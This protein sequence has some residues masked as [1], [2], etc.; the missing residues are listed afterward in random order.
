MKQIGFL[1]LIFVSVATTAQ[2]KQINKQAID[3]SMFK[4]DNLGCFYFVND[5]ELVK[6][7]KLLDTLCTYDDFSWGEISF[8]DVSDPLQVLVFYKDFNR[9]I[10][11]DRNF[12]ELRDPVLLD[13]LEYYY[14][15]VIATSHYS[16]FLIFDNQSSEV[17]HLDKNL[18]EMQRGSS[19]YSYT[20]GS[21]IVS[22]QVSVNYIVLQ[23][24]ENKV[25]VLDKFANYYTQELVDE[26]SELS[27][28]NNTLDGLNS[29]TIN[30]WV[31]TSDIGSGKHLLSAANASQSNALLFRHDNGIISMFIGVN[32]H[33]FTNSPINDNAWHQITVTRSS[34]N[35]S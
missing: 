25:I 9:L 4:L 12:A 7:D 2:I 20:D 29:L 16:G 35:V 21:E 22:M 13:D 34:N 24:I 5:N 17:V 26:N 8:F 10:Y 14:V 15:D 27:L 19:L 18:K 11:L 32:N 33:T 6:T 31:K 28:D 1:I 30:F 3:A 23:T